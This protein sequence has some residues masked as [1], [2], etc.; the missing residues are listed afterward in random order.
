[1]APPRWTTP[2]QHQFLTGKLEQFAHSQLTKQ[3][4]AFLSNVQSEWT[5]KWPVEEAVLGEDGPAD[6]ADM[7]EDQLEAIDKAYGKLEDVCTL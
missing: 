6:K 5:E 4:A 1:M 7:T 3:V 2:E